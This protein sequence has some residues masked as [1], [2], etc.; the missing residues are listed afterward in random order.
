MTTLK[1]QKTPSKLWWIFAILILSIFV[2][3]QMP[4]AWIVQ[5]YAPNTPYIQWISGNLWQGSASWQVPTPQ[6]MQGTQTNKQLT[7]NLSW[8]WQPL[9]LFFGKFSNKLQ[10][11]TGQSKL[12]GNVAL[13]INSWEIKSFSGRIHPDTLANLVD[14]E[15][16]E[17]PINVNNLVISHHKKTGLKHADGQLTWAGGDLGYP[18]SGKLYRIVMPSMR[19]NISTQE[20]KKDKKNAASGQVLHAHLTDQ[21]D[22]RLGDFYLDNSGMLDVNLTQRLLENMPEYKG[23]APLDTA[24]VSIRQPLLSLNSN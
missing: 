6:G 9:Q 24:V 13:G 12:K 7:G 1:K 11:T 5:K 16:P 20:Q 8:Q 19:A 15:L 14:W 3:V 2:V 4:V 21:K 23:S 22:K 10:I 17:A 18:N